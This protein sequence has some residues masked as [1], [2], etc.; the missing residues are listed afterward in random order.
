MPAR[1]SASEKLLKGDNKTHAARWRRQHRDEEL[2]AQKASGPLDPTPP[3]WMTKN[4]QDT[5]IE[6]TWR[7][8]KGTLCQADRAII[9][10]GAVLLEE[11][12]RTRGQLEDKRLG[13]LIVILDKLGMT[14]SSRGKV[15][16]LAANNKEKEQDNPL[17]E[18]SESPGG[19]Q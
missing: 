11:F 8:H 19:L 7:A 15:A 13:K 10:T 16:I 6:F 9:E 5:Y 17:N 12:R 2:E 18:F 3:D 1:K 4:Q 14:P